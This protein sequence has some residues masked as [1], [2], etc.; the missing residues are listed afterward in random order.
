MFSFQIH[1][2]YSLGHRTHLKQAT[3][4]IRL[5]EECEDR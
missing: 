3:E 2:S 4:Q 1:S 5:A